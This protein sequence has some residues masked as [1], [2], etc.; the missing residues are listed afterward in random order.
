MSDLPGVGRLVGAADVV[1]GA[2]SVLSTWLPAYVAALQ[3]AMPDVGIVPPALID[4][5]PLAGV[6]SRADQV[7]AVFCSSPGTT[8]AFVRTGTGAWGAWYLLHVVLVD[9]DD[10]WSA[11]ADRIQRWASLVTAVLLAHPDLDGAVEQLEPTDQAF[12]QVPGDTR[13]LAGTTCSFRAFVPVITQ[14]G[15]AGPLQVLPGSGQP[16]P[17]SPP[18]TEVDLTVTRGIPT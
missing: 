4:R 2:Q 6:M 18:V 13:T 3:Q 17:D 8:G 1:A 7:P 9:R 14:Q 15:P 12:G 16:P 5:V 11:T 10:D